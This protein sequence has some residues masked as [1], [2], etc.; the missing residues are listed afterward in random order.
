MQNE[1]SQIISEYKGAK[2]VE[3]ISSEI[4]RIE[5]WSDEDKNMDY[6]NEHLF[7]IESIDKLDVEI[8]H[9]ELYGDVITFFKEN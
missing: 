3:W 6:F 9:G 1:N 2:E 4:N 8:L 7:L 5:F